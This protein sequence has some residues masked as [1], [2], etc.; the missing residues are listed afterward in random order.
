MRRQRVVPRISPRQAQTRKAHRRRGCNILA[1]ERPDSRARQA[2]RITGV[3]RT[4]A[5]RA[6]TRRDEARQCRR[7]GNRCRHRPVIDLVRRAQ[8]ADRQRLCAHTQ[9]AT[10]NTRYIIA[11]ERKG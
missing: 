2:H 9:G 7:P 6:S 3:R 1:V 11:Q 10:T 4:I 8:T 5:A